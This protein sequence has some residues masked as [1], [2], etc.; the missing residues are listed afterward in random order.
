MST[1]TNFLCPFCGSDPVDIPGE[2][3]EPEVVACL[4]PDCPIHDQEFGI[5]QWETRTPYIC[6]ECNGKD[7]PKLRR[8][9][10]AEKICGVLAGYRRTGEFFDPETTR[11][12]AEWMKS[13][14]PEAR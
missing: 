8:M 13:T 9:Q 4:N 14:E 5:E 12:L 6:P 10:L 2:P 7:S 11:Y 3:G 1:V